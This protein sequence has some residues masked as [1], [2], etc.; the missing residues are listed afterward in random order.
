MAKITGKNLE[1]NIEFTSNPRYA[2]DPLADNDLSRKKYVDDQVA[3]RILLTEKGAASGVATL[4]ANSKIPSSQ[5][6]ALA[7]TEVF[8]VADITARD[9]LTIGTGDGEVQEGDVAKVT[10]ASADPNITS[11]PASYIYDGSA[12][13]MLNINDQ[14]LSVNGQTGVVALDTDDISEGSTNKYYATSLFNTDFATKTTDDLTEGS[15][16]KYFTDAAAKAAVVDDTAYNATSWDGVTDVAPSK[17]ALRD[18]I[19]DLEAQIAANTGSTQGREV[20]TLSAGDI[21]NG[22]VDLA[23]EVLANSLQVTPIGGIPQEPGVDFIESLEGGVT[24]V[25]FAGDLL[26][27]VATDKVLFNYEF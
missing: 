19:V 7:I 10:D 15:T 26:D 11:G 24:R 18:K 21:T 17:N 2:S 13:V 12:W 5:L 1:T 22:Y 23:E 25:T 27:L 6:P 4:D 8:T 14:V 20:K 9:A 16:N 3:L